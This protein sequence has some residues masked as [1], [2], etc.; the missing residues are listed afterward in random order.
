[1]G[2]YIRPTDLPIHGWKPF[3]AQC[4]SEQ[5]SPLS[6]RTYNIMFSACYYDNIM[7]SD[8]FDWPYVHARRTNNNVLCINYKCYFR[9]LIH[10]PSSPL[11][12]RIFQPRRHT[13]ITYY[14]NVNAT[15]AYRWV[16]RITR[17][18]TAA[19]SVRI[20]FEYFSHAC[21]YRV[22]LSTGWRGLRM[23][24]L[25]FGGAYNEFKKKNYFCYCWIIFIFTGKLCTAI[26]VFW[27]DQKTR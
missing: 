23:V 15:R 4:L 10:V 8:V 21:Q 25:C 20:S 2:L 24:I 5:S 27:N 18:F 1:M 13:W 19:C 7:R 12:N 26:I 16:I 3:R 22:S 14:Y 17:F 11:G 9:T 6:S